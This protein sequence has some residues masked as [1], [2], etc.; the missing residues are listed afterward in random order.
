MKYTGWILFGLLLVGAMHRRA[1]KLMGL[2]SGVAGVA[3]GTL[4]R[5]GTFT[6]VLAVA[7]MSVQRAHA[8][9]G[10]VLSHQKISDTE[11]NFTGT[12]DNGDLFGSSAASLGGLDG[13][14]PSVLA[15]AV[16]AYSDDDG[17]GSRGAVWVLFLDGGPAC[18]WD[19]ADGDG[20]VGI[21]DFLGLLAQWSQ[22]GTSCDFDGGGV[23]NERPTTPTRKLCCWRV[24]DE[25][26]TDDGPHTVV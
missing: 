22:V 4:S 14:G 17:G 15:L 11:G 21:L 2:R 20:T 7:V 12:L 1:I 3:C 16:G 18:P 5:T 26:Y 8:Q 13:A 24:T 19:C 10:W 6:L 23:R 25:R 9:P